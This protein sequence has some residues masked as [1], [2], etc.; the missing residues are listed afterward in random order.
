MKPP[1]QQQAGA[2]DADTYLTAP[3][4]PPQTPQEKAANDD[5][6]KQM[7]ELAILLKQNNLD[8]AVELA[9]QAA[10]HEGPLIE[11][12]AELGRRFREE[13]TRPKPKPKPKPKR[14]LRLVGGSET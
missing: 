12:F 2:A 9:R 14:A 11:H 5:L 6:L 7:K 3:P 10:R 4:M 13:L 8:S 1:R